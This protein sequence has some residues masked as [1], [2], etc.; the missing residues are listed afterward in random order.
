MNQ[1]QEFDNVKAH[2]EDIGQS[3]ILQFQDKINPEQGLS[4][5]NQVKNLD[6]SRIPT[7]VEKYVLNDGSLKVPEHFDP[8]PSWPPVPKTAEQAEKY[9]KAVQI[10]EN[11]IRQGKVAGFVV[12]GGQG[13]RLGFDGPK[14]NYPISPI[15]KKTLFRIFAE[16]LLAASKKYGTT[17]PFYIMTSPLN[18]NATVEIFESADYYGLGKE[19]VV[20]F[21]QGTLP[22]F[23]F[24]GKI[25]LADKHKIA[26]SPD[27]HGGSLKALY[28]S[29]AVADMKKRGVRYLSYWQVDNPLI[30]PIDPLFV[31]LHVADNAEMSSKALLKT[32]PLE[33]VGNFCLVDGKVTVIEYSDL[34]D[35]AA[36]RKTEDGSLAFE[37][38]SIGIHIISVSF[39]EKLNADG[40]F[41]LPFH[42]AVKKIPHI[43]KNGNAIEPDEPNGIKLETFVFDAIPMAAHSIILQ[44][45][46]EEEFAPV[47]NAAGV[48]SA[49][50]THQM[51]IDR[52]A[53]WLEKA[54]IT[55]PRKPDDTPDCTLE[56]APSFAL[57]ADDVKPKTDEIPELTPGCI[58]YL[59]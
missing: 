52:A 39:I 12:A 25:L 31:G 6:F 47:K 20:I 1:M 26:T 55:V 53:D 49:E 2:L 22:N 51:M 58:I 48:D 32:G 50:V 43:D 34:P 11:L 40:D 8:A 42:R 44:T 18:H 30:H 35:E 17:I 41:A 57:T 24:N 7:W 5:L 36:H 27:G 9:A 46:R 15:K 3:H 37:L 59:E 23:G 4:L 21:Q 10:G 33:K 16:N 54:G 28:Q 56:I 29:G 14:G 19:N 13:T 38:G 45:R